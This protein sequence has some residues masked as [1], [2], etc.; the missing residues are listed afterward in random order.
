MLQGSLGCSDHEIV[1]LEM[2]RAVRRAQSKLRA[3]D[4][5]I[6]DS[7]L[8]RNLL[9]RI[10]WDRTLEGRGAQEC[11]GISKDHLLQAQK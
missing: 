5:R 8:F 10:P 7:G 9:S 2:L 1:E 3:L 4:F 6:A 11:L